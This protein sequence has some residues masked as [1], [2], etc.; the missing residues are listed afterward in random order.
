MECLNADF[1]FENICI[2][3]LKRLQC[4][5]WITNLKRGRERE[6]EER[7]HPHVF[8]L[9]LSLLLSIFPKEKIHHFTHFQL[10]HRIKNSQLVKGDDDTN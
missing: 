8:F 7:D 5:I 3:T 9:S 6:R 1:L 2:Y 4:F 10:V